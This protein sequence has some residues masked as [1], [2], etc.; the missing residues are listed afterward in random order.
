MVTYGLCQHH[1]ENARLSL[2]T[3]KHDAIMRH[4]KAVM[5]AASAYTTAY[6]L[7]TSKHVPDNL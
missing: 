7:R 2:A 6:T 3:L 4:L 1:M 5:R